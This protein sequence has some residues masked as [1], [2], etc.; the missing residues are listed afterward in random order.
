M[1]SEKS[2]LGEKVTTILTKTIF[3]IG[4]KKKQPVYLNYTGCFLINHISQSTY[5]LNFQ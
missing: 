2:I 1:I 4:F 3:I 5:L